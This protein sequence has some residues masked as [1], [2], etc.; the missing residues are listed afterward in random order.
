MTRASGLSFFLGKLGFFFLSAGVILLEE[1]S[2]VEPPPPFVSFFLSSS[3]IAPSRD[4]PIPPQGKVVGEAAWQPL[5]RDVYAWFLFLLSLAASFT[6][7]VSKGTPSSFQDGRLVS[8]VLFPPGLQP[9][10]QETP[11]TVGAFL[12]TRRAPPPPPSR[13]RHLSF[14]DHDP[15]SDPA[16]PLSSDRLRL[17]QKPIQSLF[18]WSGL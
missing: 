3:L 18:L 12:S 16:P 6:R 1:A 5:P 4:G 14:F 8:S 11:H 17:F 15:P 2:E 10:S 13:R 7:Q 9:P